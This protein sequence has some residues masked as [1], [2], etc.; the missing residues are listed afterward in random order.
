MSSLFLRRE[1]TILDLGAI[2]PR[3]GRLCRQCDRH[4]PAAGPSTCAPCAKALR[5]ERL[6][7]KEERAGIDRIF[8]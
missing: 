5:R 3:V 2:R 1:L 4:L 6:E 8:G 7:L